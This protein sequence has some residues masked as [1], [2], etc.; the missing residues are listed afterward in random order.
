MKIKPPIKFATKC[1]IAELRAVLKQWKTKPQRPVVVVLEY[2]RNVV[3]IHDPRIDWAPASP[4][5]AIKKYCRLAPQ[6]GDVQISAIE[7]GLRIAFV[8]S[9]GSAT[10]RIWLLPYPLAV[11]S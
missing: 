2:D 7:D 11:C 3:G 8:H 5:M 9:E 4:I 1:T 10:F 6:D